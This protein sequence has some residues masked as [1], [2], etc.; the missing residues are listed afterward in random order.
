MLSQPVK[1]FLFHSQLSTLVAYSV[2]ARVLVFYPVW[3]R[4][5]V[6]GHV[7]DRSV[8]TSP[9]FLSLASEEPGKLLST[10]HVDAASVFAGGTIWL[11]SPSF[12]DFGIPL[13][14]W[15]S[16]TTQDGHL[17]IYDHI[18]SYITEVQHF[19]ERIWV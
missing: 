14:S 13:L 4:V 2:S 18:L 6:K 11:I 7:R 16:S 19:F 1:F 8:R 3:A 17:T 15:S 12:W 10:E 5:S 9:T